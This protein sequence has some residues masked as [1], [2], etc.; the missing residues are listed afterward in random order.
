MK[1]SNNTGGLRAYTGSPAEAIKLHVGTGFKYIDYSIPAVEDWLAVTDE[2]GCTA[3][4]HGFKLV[5]AH[6]PDY[7]PMDRLDDPAYH[8]AGLAH[9][10][11]AVEACAILGIPNIIVHPGYSFDCR[12][13]EDRDKYFEI[14]RAFYAKLYDLME[15]WNVRV[16]IENSAE[17]HMRGRYSFLTPGEM[18]DF[19][20]FCG[21]PLLGACWDFGHAQMRGTTPYDDLMGLGQNLTAVHVHDNFGQGDDHMPP[22]FGTIDMDSVMRGLIDVGF[23]GYFDFEAVSMLPY[24][25]DH[26]SDKFKKVPL[27][28][29][30]A[31]LKMLYE[32][33]RACL[34]AYGIFEE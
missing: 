32:I 16:C 18:N 15:K 25:L 4:A 1:L 20:A 31:S 30:R 33:G 2:V 19:L 22:F 11:H 10:R 21:H 27:E 23:T 12:Y 3:A 14:N 5:Q 8:E 34:E 13:P 7:N 17:H 24:R 9:I 28:V 29:K 6:A 26:G